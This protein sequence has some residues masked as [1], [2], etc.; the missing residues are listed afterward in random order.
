M[1]EKLPKGSIVGVS[2]PV[3][4]AE[5]NFPVRLFEAVSL[6]RLGLLGEVAG[7]RGAQ[8]D[9]Q[10]C[11]D[12]AGLSAG[13][14]VL[15]TG[16]PFGVDLGPGL[17]GEILDA[18]GRPLRALSKN[19]IYLG[20]GQCP[21]VS[22]SGKLWHF[23]SRAAAGQPLV[24][25]DVL[26]TVA[27]GRDF[28]HEVLVPSAPADFPSA[29]T[30]IA[31]EGDY[32]ASDCVCRLANGSHMTLT[33]RWPVR[34][35]RPFGARLPLDRP[36]ITG[37]RALDTLFP[38]PLG[39]VALLAGES[40][41]GKTVA[42]RS[43][44]KECDADVVVA[45]GC[46]K[47]SN[48]IAETIEEFSRFP[49]GGGTPLAERAVFVAIP[50][51]APK[52][53]K[54]VGVHLGMTLAEYYRDMGRNV[55]V[56]LDSTSRWAEAV[57]GISGWLGETLCE[58]GYPASLGGRISRLCQRAGRVVTLGCSPLRGSVTLIHTVSPER[59]DFSE[60]VTQMGL[61]SSGAVWA[62][63]K[64][65]A[66]A[67]LFP[68]LDVRRSYSLYADALS[69][70]V[71]KG[72][73]KDP[74][75]DIGK[76][77]RLTETPEIFLREARDLLPSAKPAMTPPRRLYREG[78]RGIKGV[79]GPLLFVENTEGVGCGEL[80]TLETITETRMGQVLEIK[81]DL[82][83]IRLFDDTFG[84]EIGLETGRA[85][86]WTEHDVMRIGGGESLRG[87]I[88]NGPGS[89]VDGGAYCGLEDFLPVNGMPLNP[90]SRAAPG[91]FIETGLSVLDLINPL[92][93]GQRLSL[94]GGPGLPVG[95]IAAQ[96]A[97]QAVIPGKEGS[98]LVVFAGMGLSSREADAFMEAF[99]ASGVMD[100]GVFLLNKADDPVGER[101][102]TPRAALTIAEYFAF[103]KDTTSSSS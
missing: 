2:G 46:G 93:C 92:A 8:V 100:G 72:T 9:I 55:L 32:A 40:G 58:E 59:G 5:A 54:E 71:T 48:E 28:L 31:S 42:S 16:K 11:E 56:A 45:V 38:L 51:N 33:Q 13:E 20:R 75:K 3:V 15:F 60:P 95:E 22:E 65:L 23:K 66:R 73:E 7:V 62:L 1:P 90:V 4:T 83:V 77:K 43:I 86:V 12:T 21:S 35:P 99:S 30:W 63:D 85:K 91:E 19:G 78:L 57:R 103:V 18:L 74:R 96:I 79:T 76:E 102:L 6:G 97:A 61:R 17:L 84:L 88:L 82:C 27:E 29:V 64:N 47:R 37:Q 98:F 44:A 50:S 41:T 25:G 70:A 49:A 36:L 14:E 26:G 39:G 94:F 101:L 34:V 81:N 68:A 87:R 67:R 69:D 52:G 10:A 89:P 80:V 24:P 53:A